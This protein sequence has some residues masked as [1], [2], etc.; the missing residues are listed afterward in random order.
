MKNAIKW[1]LGLS[2]AAILMT[3]FVYGVMDGMATQQQL[4]ELAAK[5]R[6]EAMAW[7][8]P[9]HCALFAGQP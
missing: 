4:N 7:P 6:C 2:A 1:M 5:K 3:C 8:R 9:A